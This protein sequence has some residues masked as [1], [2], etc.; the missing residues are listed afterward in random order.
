MCN[1]MIIYVA[2]SKVALRLSTPRG[3]DSIWLLHRCGPSTAPGPMS[4]Q[5]QPLILPT[6]FPEQSW[7]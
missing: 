4:G 6:G 3:Q 5:Q 2:W 1:H 7:T